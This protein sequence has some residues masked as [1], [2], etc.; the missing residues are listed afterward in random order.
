MTTRAAAYAAVLLDVDGVLV[1]SEHA[2]VALWDEVCARL[3]RASP[4]ERDRRH[5][6]GCSVE[7]TA[8]HL[9]PD[10]G[11]EALRQV[12]AHVTEL[13]PDLPVTEVPGAAAL[14]R[15]LHAQGARVALVT[16]ASS[17]RLDRVLQALGAEPYVTATVTWGQSEGKPHPG[18]YLLAASLLGVRAD[19]CVVVEDAVAGVRSA[20]TAG[21][22]CIGLAAPNSPAGRA[23]LDAGA[24]RVLETLRDVAVA[25][26]PERLRA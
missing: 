13:E 21:A 3:G 10:A 20:V 25:L 4:T 22:T 5:I 11:P 2:V 9:F 6:V 18:P 23:L 1:D 24:S 19:D 8:H 17:E 14:L 7:H 16:G 26:V 15:G 12:R